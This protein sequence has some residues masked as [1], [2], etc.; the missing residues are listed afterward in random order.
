MTD[1][2]EKE[3]NSIVCYCNKVNK[4]EIMESIIRENI[5]LHQIRLDTKACTNGNCKKNNPSGKCCSKDILEI[6]KIYRK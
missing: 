6:I 3:D 2:K 1:W 5:N 4:K